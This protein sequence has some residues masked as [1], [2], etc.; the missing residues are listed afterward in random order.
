MSK[1]LSRSQAALDDLAAA[2]DAGH[3]PYMVRELAVDVASRAWRIA[4]RAEEVRMKRRGIQS[5]F[6]TIQHG[7]YSVT[8]DGREM[9]VICPRCEVR[10]DIDN[11]G[12]IGDRIREH[13]KLACA[14]DAVMSA[15]GYA[16]E[17]Y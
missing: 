16:M 17:Q 9:W 13:R 5:G 10:L 8:T 11:P 6:T 1:L 3:S 12:L 2:L 7:E 4:F 14:G 15:A